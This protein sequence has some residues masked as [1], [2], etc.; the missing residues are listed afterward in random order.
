MSD[1]LSIINSD[2]IWSIFNIKKIKNNLKEYSYNKLLL[3]L[4]ICDLTNF[5]KQPKVQI[6]QKESNLQITLTYVIK[7]MNLSDLQNLSYLS[8][9]LVVKPSIRVDGTHCV[10][11]YTLQR[12]TRFHVGVHNFPREATS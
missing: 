7:V 10:H 11:A 5:C 8:N 6:V 3:Q 9:F 2:W 4:S 12:E 1:E